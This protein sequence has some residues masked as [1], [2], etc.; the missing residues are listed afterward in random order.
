MGVKDLFND[1]EINEFEIE[2]IEFF[3]NNKFKYKTMTIEDDLKWTSEYLEFVDGKPKIHFNILNKLKIENL[4]EIPWNNLVYYECKKCEKEYSKKLNECGC[5][6]KDFKEKRLIKDLCG[7]NKEWKSMDV[8]E[9]WKFINKL[10]PV[11]GDKILKKMKEIDSS[12][13]DVK[14]N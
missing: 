7:I 9:K 3:G 11:I 2:G 6:N 14:K 10:K 8:E 1:E 12:N 4:L 13:F 5:K